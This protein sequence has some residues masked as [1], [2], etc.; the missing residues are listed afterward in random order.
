MRRQVVQTSALVCVV[1]AL[2]A[3][4]AALA[5]DEDALFGAPKAKRYHSVSVTK[6]GNPQELVK[7]TKLRIG[8]SR[9][10]GDHAYWYSGCNSFQ[11]EIEVDDSVI[12]IDEVDQTLR[13]CKGALSGQDAFFAEFFESDPS[14][15]ASG[16]NLTLSNERVTI[17]LRRRRR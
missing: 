3:A 15:R 13:G 16:R 9:K 5:G 7:G 1:G 11:A 6:D 10:Q 12:T 4:P 2:T 8:F 17:E 14:W